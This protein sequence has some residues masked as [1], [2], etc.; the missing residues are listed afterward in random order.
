MMKKVLIA[1]LST[2]MMLMAV[3][4]MVFAEANPTPS[5]TITFTTDESDYWPNSI[6]VKLTDSKASKSTSQNNI[7]SSDPWTDPWFGTWE[8]D[9]NKTYS[10]YAITNTGDFFYCYSDTD[11]ANHEVDSEITKSGS[12]ID[13]WEVYDG[14]SIKLLYSKGVVQN[15]AFEPGKNY[16]FKACFNPVTKWVKLQK[17]IFEASSIDTITLTEDITAN[18]QSDACLTIPSGKKITLNLN[19][20]KLDH[21]SSYFAKPEGS[22]IHVEEGA[23]LIL[24]DSSAEKTGMLTGGTSICG[25]G[26]N[27]DGTLTIESGTIYNCRADSYQY[28]ISGNGGAIYNNGTLVISGGLI[29]NCTAYCSGGA[30][31]NTPSAT[32]FTMTGGK[33]TNCSAYGYNKGSSGGAIYNYDNDVEISNVE[34]KDCSAKL[35]GGA[36]YNSGNIDLSNVSIK[37]CNASYSAFEWGPYGRGGAI[38]NDGRLYDGTTS[39][40][41]GVVTIDGDSVIDGCRAEECGGGIYNSGLLL[42]SNFSIINCD[43]TTNINFAGGGIYNEKSKEATNPGTVVLTDVTID[44]CASK[45]GAGIANRDDT[46][47]VSIDGASIITNNTANDE[48]GAAFNNGTMSIGGTTS[49]TNNLSHGTAGG[50]SNHNDNLKVYGKVV[51]KNNK[52]LSGTASSESVS[53]IYAASKITVGNND[54][55]PESGMNIGVTLPSGTGR[56]T[57]NDINTEGYK[58]YFFSDSDLREVRYNTGKYLELTNLFTVS[59]NTNGKGTAP[60]PIEKIKYDARINRPADPTTSGFVFYQ[61][62]KEMECINPWN[63]DTDTVKENRTL[64]AKWGS[65][66]YEITDG[67]QA[68]VDVTQGNNVL[69]RSNADF[70]K[71]VDVKVD[72]TI[73]SSNNYVASSGSTKVTMK[74]SYLSTLSNGVHTLTIIS[75]DGAASTTFT[76]NRSVKPSPH[77]DVPNTGIR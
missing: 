30:I 22:V 70:S 14:T 17:T 68:V 54:L 18:G 58:E 21:N 39:S 76:I 23:E 71:F 47:I 77:Y 60:N 13:H 24:K 32:S 51:V 57:K 73:V 53:N 33:I 64:Y 9:Y 38:Y 31:Y 2:F 20:Y 6:G 16:I 49:I 35:N 25:G 34:I 27:N 67:K 40:L 37:S 5:Q 10:Y 48:G 15:L 29:D 65:S 56:F 66:N 41:K 69:F 72:N 8:I 7:S 61:W 42:G 36:I 45:F 43:T 62:Y 4:A 52:Q 26:I 3:P 11:F 12:S 50:I 59:F 44:N 46:T 1:I 19:G 75:S 63:F 28:E 74:A 55:L